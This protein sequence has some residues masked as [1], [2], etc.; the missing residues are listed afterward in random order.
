MGEDTGR[1]VGDSGFESQVGG[2]ST[3]AHTRA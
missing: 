2:K 1:G 3:S